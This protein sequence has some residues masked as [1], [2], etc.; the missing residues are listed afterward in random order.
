MAAL[1]DVEPAKLAGEVSEALV[2]AIIRLR[3]AKEPQ[4][5][6]E[7]EKAV[8]V[9]YHTHTA[10]MRATRPGLHEWEVVRKETSSAFSISSTS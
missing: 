1:L 6:L 7:M 2:G 3:S 5:V 4:E 9:S 10:A 8:E